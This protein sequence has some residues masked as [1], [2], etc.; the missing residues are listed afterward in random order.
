MLIKPHAPSRRDFLRAGMYAV[1]LSAG[2]PSLF[3][4]LSLAQ[5][6]QAA[7]RDEKQPNRQNGQRGDAVGPQR[8]MFDDGKAGFEKHGIDGARYRSDEG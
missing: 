5:V 6:A 1:G 4:Q 3:E 8:T 2:L 7:S